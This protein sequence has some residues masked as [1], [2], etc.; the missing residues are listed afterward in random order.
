MYKR[1]ETKDL[2]RMRHHKKKNKIEEEKRIVKMMIEMYQNHLRKK[3]NSEEKAI[4]FDE[5]LKYAYTRLDQCKFGEQKPLC[6]RC[7]IHCYHPEMKKKIQKVM[8]YSG[9]RM[10]FCYPLITI[11]HL[12]G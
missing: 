9:P 6:K 7:P 1:G 12:L 2:I 11:K 4:D 5:L 8:R 3:K 10:I